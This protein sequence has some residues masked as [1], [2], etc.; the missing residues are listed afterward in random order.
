TMEDAWNFGFNYVQTIYF[1]EN[2]SVTLSFDAYRTEFINQFV[3]NQDRDAHSIFFYMSNEKSFSNALQAEAKFS[4]FDEHWTL[5]LAG[6]FNDVRQTL[7]GQLRIKPLSPRWKALVV[8]NVK[9]NMDKWQFDLT[10]QFN[11]RSRLPNTGG[12]MGEYSTPY[13]IMHAQITK[14]FKY[15]DL[16]VGCE[17]IFDQVQKDPIIDASN[18]FGNDFD[19]TVVWGS[20][21]RRTFYIGIRLT[22]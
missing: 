7:D 16:Y 6:R 13:V 2:S 17:N 15:V 14:R 10:T 18:P 4:F 5:T 1:N 3:V 19:A 21:M 12:K 9:T 8:N 22:I 11:G 20:L